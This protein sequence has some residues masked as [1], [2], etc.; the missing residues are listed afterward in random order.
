MIFLHI[1]PQVLTCGKG[2]HTGQGLKVLNTPKLV[3]VRGLQSHTV[4]QVWHVIIQF[5]I[6]RHDYIF[7]R[8]SVHPN[9]FAHGS[10]LVVFR[11]GYDR[12]NPF[13]PGLLLVIAP[14]DGWIHTCNNK[15]FK[16]SSALGY[17]EIPMLKST[18]LHKYFK[19]GIWLASSTA[20]SQSEAMLEN[21]C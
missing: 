19:P 4:Q 1:I 13:S 15:P 18:L 16:T 5:I 14:S 7:Q 21:H 12:F 9:D 20:A 11:W 6:V 3:I 10:Y 2:G 8:Y 17:L